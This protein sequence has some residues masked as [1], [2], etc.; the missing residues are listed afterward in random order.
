MSDSIGQKPTKPTDEHLNPD[1]Q[2]EIDGSSLLDS[3]HRIRSNQRILRRFRKHKLAIFGAVFMT[4]LLFFAV[5]APIVT[6][7]DPLYADLAALRQAPSVSHW[8][9]TDLIGRDV[10]SRVIYGSRISLAVGLG[11]VAIYV[12]IGT[13]LGALSGYF[14]GIIDGV[15]MRIT[16]TFLTLPSLLL[17][18]VF[19]SVVGPS[20]SS[21]M[22]VIGL[23]GWPQTVR[24]VRGQFLSLREEEYVVAARMIG[25]G[26]ARIII[27]HMLPNVVA[28]L[29]VV[30]T[31]GVATAIILEASLGFLGLGVQ[32]PTPSW[33]GM[34]NEARSPTVLG[35]LQ[36]LWL[37]PGLAIAL[38][39]L[40]VNFIGDGLIDAFDPHSDN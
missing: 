12:L 26:T 1:Q 36:W 24:I 17:V 22:I 31:F 7:H 19:V 9:G 14:G 33:G 37:S 11:A 23:L 15:I 10:W 27:R 39:V 34:L 35:G 16:E 4:I 28:A 30:A 25:A 5:A 29:T 2:P 13:L 40:A 8:L 6:L 21:V 3:Q 18:I 38:T 32:P 20:V